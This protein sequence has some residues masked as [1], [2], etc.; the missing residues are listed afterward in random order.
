MSFKIN[1][2]STF[3]SVEALQAADPEGA[4]FAQA[5]IDVVKAH[6]FDAFVVVALKEPISSAGNVSMPSAVLACSC[7]PVNGSFSGF[8]TYIRDAV[9]HTLEGPGLQLA[10]RKMIEE[11]KRE[12]PLSLNEMFDEF[13]RRAEGDVS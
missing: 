11:A 9:T 10:G 7:K 2:D 6:G 13:A 1:A 4:S 12:K 5:L 3:D 8:L